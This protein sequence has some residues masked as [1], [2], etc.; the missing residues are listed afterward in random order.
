MHLTIAEITTSAFYALF[1]LLFFQRIYGQEN[2]QNTINETEIDDEQINQALELA[3]ALL[4]SEEAQKAQE[5]SLPNKPI[6]ASYPRQNELKRQEYSSVGFPQEQIRTFSN[7]ERSGPEQPEQLPEYEQRPY[8]YREPFPGPTYPRPPPRPI[9]PNQANFYYPKSI[10]YQR[11]SQ[12]PPYFGGQTYNP[13]SYYPNYSPF[14]PPGE[15]YRSLTPY[16]DYPIYPSVNYE[17]INNPRTYDENSSSRL[18]QSI[19]TLRQELLEM[20]KN[21]KRW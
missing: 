16:R 2:G 7:D 9:L 21:L 13:P 14:N 10:M 11:Q 15:M 12:Q 3:R 6:E 17:S 8:P 18:I 5:N 19:S 20:S 4:S 1:I